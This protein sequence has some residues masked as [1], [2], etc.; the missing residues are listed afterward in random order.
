MPPS[1][2]VLVV[3]DEVAV[4]HLFSRVLASGGFS[5]MTATSGEGALLLLENGPVPAAILLDLRM[6]GA[7]GFTFL[8]QLRADPRY[9]SVPVAIVTGD[10]FLDPELV[11]AAEALNAKVSFKPIY[12]AEILALV[13]GLIEG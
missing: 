8:R 9:T 4:R 6:P 13:R 5:C 7:G 2:T 1:A 12:N 3:D 11:S 10:F